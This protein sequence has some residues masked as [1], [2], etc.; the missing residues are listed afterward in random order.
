MNCRPGHPPAWFIVGEGGLRGPFE[1]RSKRN[2]PPRQLRHIL[3]ILRTTDVERI[4]HVNSLFDENGLN[5]CGK[6]L[7]LGMLLSLYSLSVLRRFIQTA[8]SSPNTFLSLTELS[9]SGTRVH[10][11]DL[12][13]IHHLP[14]LSILFLNNTG[15]GNEAVYL[16]IPLKRTLTQLT[17]ATNPDIDSTSVPAIL[18]LSKLCYLSIADTSIDMNGLRTLVKRV[19]RRGGL[20]ILRFRG[21][22]RIILTIVP[23]APF[24]PVD[25]RPRG[26][27]RLIVRCAST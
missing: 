27:Q 20:W 23:P 9:F 25:N 22:A 2:G 10:D 12:I 17:L 3:D 4:S 13:H 5:L 26:V 7:F 18:L 11:F 1:A 15:T 24:L 19:M 14:K 6:D 16:L 21:G 8:F